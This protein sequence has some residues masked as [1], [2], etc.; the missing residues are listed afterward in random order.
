MQGGPISDL[1][2]FGEEQ[3]GSGFFGI[4][5]AAYSRSDEKESG[6]ISKMPSAAVKVRRAQSSER[7]HT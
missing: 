6:E 7:P 3:L 5:C 1:L 4:I 2:R